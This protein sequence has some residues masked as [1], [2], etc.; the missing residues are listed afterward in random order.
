MEGMFVL[1]ASGFTLT[2]AGGISVVGCG[3]VTTWLITLVAGITFV[4]T[5]RQNRP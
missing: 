3:S 5:L 1:V 2:I 4:I